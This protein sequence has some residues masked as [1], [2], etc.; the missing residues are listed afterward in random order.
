MYRAKIILTQG[1]YE[2]LNRA[3]TKRDIPQ[4]HSQRLGDIKVY[5]CMFVHLRK[6][7]MYLHVYTK[8]GQPGSNLKVRC[9]CS[10]SISEQRLL[11]TKVGSGLI[12]S[13]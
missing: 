12:Y 8:G 3:A 6:S 2:V 5:T 4:F 11:R 9:I 10:L 1:Y 7:C 13:S